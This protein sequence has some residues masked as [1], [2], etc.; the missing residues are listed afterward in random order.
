MA[1]RIFDILFSLLGLLVV[2]CLLF[3][4]WIMASLDTRSN[5]LFVQKR[6][7]QW[8][9]IFS[10]Y[11][12]K[13]MHPVTG[14]ISRWGSFLRQSKMD[15]LPQLWN[16][17][18][19]DMSFV[20]FRPDVPGYYDLLEGE[21]RKIL[22]LQPGITSAASLKYRNEALLLQEQ[23][24]PLHYNDTVI[25]PDKVRLNLAYYYRRSFWGDVRIL[26]RTV[27]G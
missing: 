18:K 19:G 22:E 20:G 21:A 26:W 4:F 12:L 6:I 15:E 9:K 14:A 13:T 17:L 23:E 8:G 5:G 3:V 11:K 24:D 1:K 27:F 2:A 25:F 16:I 7:G 10:I